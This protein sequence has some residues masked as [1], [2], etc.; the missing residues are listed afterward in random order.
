MGFILKK[1]L[2]GIEIHDL[3]NVILETEMKKTMRCQIAI[4]DDEKADISYI[5][6]LVLIWAKKQNLEVQLHSYLSAEAFLFAYEEKK[7]FDILLLDIEMSGMDGV[8]MAKKI[9]QENE[10]V[11]IIFITGYSE[12]IAE[13]YEVAALHYLMKPVKEEKLFAVLDRAVVK[14]QTNERMLYLDIGSEMVRIPFYEIRY[15]EV[16]KNYVTIHAKQEYVVKKTLAEFEKE[17]DE[18]FFRLGRSWLINLK[19]VRRVTKTEVHL[20]DG[21]IIP[22]PRGQYEAINRAII[23]GD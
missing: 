15:L 11:Q 17:L 12:Y 1:G 4:C 21:S 16:M 9:R 3:L 18:R 22:L 13:G 8:T 2:C 6:Q 14:M 23:A 5:E 10:S 20:A 19:M 7:D